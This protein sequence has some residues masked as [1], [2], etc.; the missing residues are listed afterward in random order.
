MLQGIVGANNR[1]CCS[2]IMTE[3]CQR[4]DDFFSWA[5]SSCHFVVA[6][7]SH[8]LSF[9]FL[10]FPPYTD[11]KISC[12]CKFMIFRRFLSSTVKVLSTLWQSGSLFGMLRGGSQRSYLNQKNCQAS[13]ERWSLKLLDLQGILRMSALG[14]WNFRFSKIGEESLGNSRDKTRGTRI[15]VNFMGRL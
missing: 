8:V 13:E 5:L 12:K 15:S 3:P 6:V 2:T 14:N 4:T 7:K 10:F 9:R 11:F 1:F